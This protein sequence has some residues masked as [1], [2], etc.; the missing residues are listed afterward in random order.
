MNTRRSFIKAMGA[1]LALPLVARAQSGA[2]SSDLV[3]NYKGP[4]CDCCGDWEKHMRASGFRVETRKVDDMDAIKRK[5]GVRDY[6][7]SCHTAL[8]GGYVI[9]GHVPASDVRRLLKEKPK[10]IG[11]TIPGM[12]ASAPGMDRKPHKPYEVLAF[13]S[14]RVWLFERH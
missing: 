3:I 8:I 12:P 11:L 7:V 13:D 14:S 9:E 6:L 2:P 5:Y 10:A 1:A 4:A